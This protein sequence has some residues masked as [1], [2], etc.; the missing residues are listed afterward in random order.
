MRPILLLLSAASALHIH[1][2]AHLA[3]MGHLEAFRNS[4]SVGSSEQKGELLKNDADNIVHAQVFN[5][6]IEKVAQVAHTAQMAM[7]E[8]VE[9]PLDFAIEAD[10]SIDSRIGAFEDRIEDIKDR[11][12]EKKESTIRSTK[13]LV[14]RPIHVVADATRDGDNDFDLEDYVRGNKY[15]EQHDSTGYRVGI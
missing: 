8:I 14:F 11:V 12:R 5:Q 4:S 15:N 2:T 6:L 9:D 10:R 3:A 13:N 7:E 1:H